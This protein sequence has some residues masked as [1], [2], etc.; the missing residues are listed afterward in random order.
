LWGEEWGL[1][2]AFFMSLEPI[3]W[4]SSQK[5]WIETTLGFFIYLGILLLLLGE[6]KKMYFYL[7]GMSLG[8]ALLSKYPAILAI[9]PI[10]AVL[11]LTD[12]LTDRKALV[13]YFFTPFIL[14]LPWIVWNYAVY[15]NDF[16]V[17]FIKFSSDSRIGS[18][19][20]YRTI[21]NI[22][23][24]VV[25]IMISTGV[26]IFR[27]FF[28]NASWKISSFIRK[29]I[30]I[31]T[32]RKIGFVF[33]ALLVFT[34]IFI[35]NKKIF[36]AFGWRYFQPPIADWRKLHGSPRYFYFYHMVELAQISVFAYLSI[37]FFRKWDKWV[38]IFALIVISFFVF[39]GFLGY[40]E[41]RLVIAATPALMILA[42]YTIKEAMS[43]FRTKVGWKKELPICLMSI[44]IFYI[45][46]KMAFYGFFVIAKNYFFFF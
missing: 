2:A 31:S 42:T 25:A 29:N 38:F 28:K 45:V 15:G 18:P 22:S 10:Y 13:I 30:T 7:S 3:Y 16:I 24:V 39:F 34:L 33:S 8:F 32:I 36:N 6:H 44:F 20:F 41:S 17:N 1:L 12:D 23:A 40:Y 46:L 4:L 11:L 21:A 19:R 14:V 37:I 35:S 43:F 27:V 9:I 26:F 5:I